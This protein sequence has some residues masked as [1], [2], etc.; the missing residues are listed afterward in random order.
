MAI[1]RLFKKQ[2]LTSFTFNRQ[3]S[4]VFDNMV[5]RSVPFYH[6]VNRLSVD[7]VLSL[8]PAGS[9]VVD[10]GCSTGHFLIE[11]ALKRQPPY[12]LIGVDN[13][14]P[15]LRQAKKKRQHPL[16]Q[17]PD[18]FCCSGHC[19]VPFTSLPGSDIKLFPTIY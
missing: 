18:R 10:L 8:V 12:R 14:S 9:T 7:T 11:L 16:S 19:Q 4:T 6:E 5:R 3:V 15:M 17:T 2:K 13:A 1:D